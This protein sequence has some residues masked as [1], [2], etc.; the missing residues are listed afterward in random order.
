MC[1]CVLIF[2]ESVKGLEIYVMDA[3]SACFMRIAEGKGGKERKESLPS[4]VLSQS[5]LLSSHF[6]CSVFLIIF[7]PF[8]HSNFIFL[9]GLDSSN[10]VGGIQANRHYI[11]FQRGRGCAHSSPSHQGTCPFLP[12][13][14]LVLCTIQEE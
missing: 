11:C 8:K 9:F 14:P 5:V 2:R 12:S 3:C 6:F 10:N 7:V 13:F 1:I 4:Y